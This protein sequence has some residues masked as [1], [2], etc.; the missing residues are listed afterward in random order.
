M[1]LKSIIVM[2]LVAVTFM[3]CASN[4]D[5]PILNERGVENYERKYFAEKEGYG[6]DKRL[7]DIFLKGYIEEGMT[8][9][10]VLMQWGPPDR[11]PNEDKT[12]WEYVNREGYMITTVKFKTSEVARL[13]VKEL[14]VESIEGDRY[15]GSPAPGSTGTSSKY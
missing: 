15:G 9:E 4:Y 11:E 1:N 14:I 13:G 2:G 8:Q 7:K 3:A 5:S 10:M 6:V 12:I